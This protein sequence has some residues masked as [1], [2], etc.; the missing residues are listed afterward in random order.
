MSCPRS[1]NA[2]SPGSP[3]RALVE[4]VETPR[5][6]FDDAA[7]AGRAMGLVGGRGH[8]I[9]FALSLPR[10][11][12][13]T[14]GPVSPA[15]DPRRFGYTPIAFALSLPRFAAQTVGPVSP[16]PDPRRFAAAPYQ[17]APFTRW[18]HGGSGRPWVD[19]TDCSLH[20]MAQWRFWSTMGRPYRRGSVFAM[21][22]SKVGRAGLAGTLIRM[23][24]AHAPDGLGRSPAQVLPPVQDCTGEQADGEPPGTDSRRFPPTHPANATALQ[25]LTLL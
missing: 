8:A 9:A 25:L 11:A 15:P 1:S 3:D 18:G 5:V 23:G 14:V 4:R 13:Q 22:L 10:F 7:G 2:S 12:A 19:P 16:A 21:D 17:G 20:Q 6:G 24:P